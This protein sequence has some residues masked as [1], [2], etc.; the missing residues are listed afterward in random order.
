MDLGQAVMAIVGSSALSAFI[1]AAAGW[2]LSKANAAKIDAE[3][4]KLQHTESADI[5]RVI[6]DR[7]NLVFAASDKHIQFLTEE[8]GQLRK[9]VETLSLELHQAR[10]EINQLRNAS[11]QTEAR[12][13]F[14]DR[15]R[16]DF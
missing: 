8:I 13:G 7:I 11:P 1:T 4:G 14:L 15:E 5:E 10:K 16:Q 12:F 3:T 6:N 9:Q 2:R